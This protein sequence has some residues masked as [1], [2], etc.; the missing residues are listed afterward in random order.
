MFEHGGPWKDPS[1]AANKNK[2]LIA[3]QLAAS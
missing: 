2:K 3:K 1:H